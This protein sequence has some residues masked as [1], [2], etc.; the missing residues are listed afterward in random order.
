MSPTEDML[1]QEQLPSWEVLRSDGNAA[2]SAG[3]KRAHDYSVDDFFTDMK[4]R[5]V[6][7]SYDPRR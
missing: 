4:K 3:S 6:T 1:M 7:P 2:V 5:R